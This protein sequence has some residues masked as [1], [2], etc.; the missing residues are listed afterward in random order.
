MAAEAKRHIV[1]VIREVAARLGNRPATCRKY[2]VHPYV[3]DPYAVQALPSLPRR[4]VSMVSIAES[5]LL[6]LLAG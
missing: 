4:A 2:Y 1:T 3:L 6:K 5:R